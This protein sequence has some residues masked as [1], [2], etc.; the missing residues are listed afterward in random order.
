MPKLVGVS[1]SFPKNRYSQE[2][3][4]AGLL[5]TTTMTPEQETGVKKFFRQVKVE[6]RHLAR[7][8][9]DYAQKLSF[10]QKNKWWLETALELS[11]EAIRDLLGK[12]DLPAHRIDL[13]ATTTVTGLAVPT[14]DARLMNVFDF[15]PNTRRLPIFGL[16][17]VAGV[18]GLNRVS[19]Y[20]KAFPTASAL[21]IATELCSL[22]FQMDDTSPANLVATS[23]FGDGC[24]V[25]LLVGDKH[26]LAERPGLKFLGAQ[27]HFFKDS[28]GVMGWEIGEKGFRVIL[29]NSVPNYVTKGLK[30]LTEASMFRYNF[31][32]KDIRFAF[33]HPGGPKVIQAIQ[34]NWPFPLS[35]YDRTWANLATY[36]NMSSVSVLTNFHDFFQQPQLPVGKGLSLAFGPAFCAEL[37]LWETQ[38]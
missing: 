5:Q 11:A 25:A 34:E 13:L 28:E 9:S 8:L 38:T 29:E 3:I 24:A 35:Y 1:L 31:D 23:L 7:P 36:G 32:L 17:C 15:A 19:E 27:S 20:L 10:D 6:S 2:E 33:T 22:T 14:L 30:P 16:G 21:F 37:G 12:F 18:A 26:P 4:L